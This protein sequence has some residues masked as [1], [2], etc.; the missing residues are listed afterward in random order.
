M[1]KSDSDM[2]SDKSVAVTDVVNERRKWVTGRIL[3][4]NLNA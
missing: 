4:C 1:V 2:H 3:F